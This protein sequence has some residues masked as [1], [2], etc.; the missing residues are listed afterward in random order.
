MEV[1][2]ALLPP[3]AAPSETEGRGENEESETSFQGL[4][5]QTIRSLSGMVDHMRN[6]EVKARLVKARFVAIDIPDV[7]AVK[8]LVDMTRGC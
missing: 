7:A 4:L 5:R 6:A 1:L 8:P 3:Q 2:Y